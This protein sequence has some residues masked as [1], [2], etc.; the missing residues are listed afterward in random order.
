MM[1][2]DNAQ[3]IPRL[4]FY[5][6]TKFH[7]QIPTGGCFFIYICDDVIIPS[8]DVKMTSRGYAQSLP[9]LLFYKCTK[10]HGQIPAGSCFFEICDDVII[11]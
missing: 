5:K 10:F 7:G 1:S 2:R 8:D 6:Y 3:S 11:T 9:R 4:L